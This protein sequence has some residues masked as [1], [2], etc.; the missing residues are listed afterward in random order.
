ESDGEL[1]HR[2]AEAVAARLGLTPV[3]FPSGHG[4]FLG[5]EYGQTGDPDGFAA[6]LRKVLAAS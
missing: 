1:A 6:T 4:G 5:G 2:G 3:P